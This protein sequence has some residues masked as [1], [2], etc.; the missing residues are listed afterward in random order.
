[1]PLDAVGGPARP[2]VIALSDARRAAPDFVFLRT[3]AG[4][5]RALF[6]QYD[7]TPLRERF[8]LDFLAQ[9]RDLLLAS[10]ANGDSL[11][12]YDAALRPRLELDVD[13]RLGFRRRAG[14]EYPA[15]GLQVLRLWEDDKGDSVVERDVREEAITAP[16]KD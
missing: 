9:P 12:L 14:H 15:A 11:I 1:L 7:F 2:G 13:I 16:A 6:E 4:T 5:L 8:R 10:S 3:T